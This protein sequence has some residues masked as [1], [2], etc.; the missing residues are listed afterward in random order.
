MN[1]N[2]GKC[3]ELMYDSRIFTNWE[4]S[5]TYNY[6][7]AK[8]LNT[9]TNNEFKEK[10]IS[11]PENIYYKENYLKCKNEQINYNH[12]IFVHNILDEMNKNIT[13]RPFYSYE[14]YNVN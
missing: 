2:N 11:N 1:S 8:K 9:K 4:T 3:P 14:Y 6:K 10:L 5:K 13:V 12:N 7:L